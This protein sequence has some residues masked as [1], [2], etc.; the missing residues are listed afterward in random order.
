LREESPTSYLSEGETP[1]NMDFTGLNE[2][3]RQNME[4]RSQAFSL[5]R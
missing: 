2:L 4:L 1:K 3:R 5:I